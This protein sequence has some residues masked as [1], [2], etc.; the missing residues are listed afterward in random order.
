MFRAPTSTNPIAEWRQPAPRPGSVDSAIVAPRGLRARLASTFSG[1]FERSEDENRRQIL[2]LAAKGPARPRLIDLGCFNGAFT[3]ELAKAARA[4]E[5][6]GV[7]YLPHHAEQAR[8]RGINVLETDLNEPLPFDDASFDLVHSNQVIEH[9]RSTDRF[10]DELARITAPGGRVILSTNNLASWHNVLSL[11]LGCQPRRPARRRRPDAPAH[12]HDARTARARLRAW[13]GNDRHPHERLLPAPTH[14]RPHRRPRRPAAR[15]LHRP[16]AGAHKMKRARQI[17]LRLVLSAG[18]IYLA[19]RGISTGHVLTALMHANPTWFLAGLAALSVSFVLGALRWRLLVRGQQIELGVKDAARLTWIGLFFTN[20][21]PTGFGGD[22][23]RIW[24]AGRRSNAVPAVTASVLADRLAS[25][26]ALTALGALGVVID[27]GALPAVVVASILSACA[28]VTLGSFLLLAP[29]PAR[30]LVRAS[31]RWQR[32][33]QA[34]ARTSEGMATYADRKELLFEAVAI[35]LVAQVCVIFAAV[36]LA[37][38]LGL[39]VGMGLMSTTIPVA[40]LATATPTNINGLGIRETVFR[41]LLVPAGV[42]PAIAVAFSLI[43][44]VAGAIVS[45]PGAIAW[46]S[47]RYR[48]APAPEPTVPGLVASV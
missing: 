47:L 43:T 11:A 8:A 5:M 37:R 23:I 16:R 18:F 20:V 9:L 2:A 26:W 39:D 42:L 7:E 48:S 34:I 46:I 44:V 6:T 22:A 38:S 31:A 30:A 15:S 13:S 10:L 27:A 12:L 17:G 19:F 3:V 41:A 29:A 40:L 24:I 21:L 1:V 32:A 4:T 14:G 28:L 25:L 35:S 45:L 33:S 36:M